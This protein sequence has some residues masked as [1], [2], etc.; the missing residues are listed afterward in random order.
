MRSPSGSRPPDFSAILACL[1]AMASAMVYPD[2]KV[3][4]ICGDGVTQTG[5]EECDD[6]N[7]VDTDACTNACTLATCGDDAARVRTELAP[8]S[9]NLWLRGFS[10]PCNGGNHR[11]L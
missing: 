5:F 4:A 1:V 8:E 3:T 6:G 10:D 2:R 9:A 7:L 11:W